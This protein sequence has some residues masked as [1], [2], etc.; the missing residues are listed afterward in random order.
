[1][2]TPSIGSRA[3]DA[4]LDPAP[5]PENTS[6]CCILV[7]TAFTVAVVAAAAIA[8]SVT[9]TCASPLVG[10]VV[11][12]ASLPL[13]AIFL[14]ATWSGS[15]RYVS[16][17]TP[18]GYAPLYSR[19]PSPLFYG[20]TRR[21]LFTES[22]AASR[23]GPPA[24]VAFA[25]RPVEFGYGARGPGLPFAFRPASFAAPRTPVG[26]GFGGVVHPM[27]P[28]AATPDAGH[29]GVGSARRR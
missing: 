25:D 17:S 26:G 1:M 21:P 3:P 2:A 16:Y 14:S 10:L 27:G 4:P 29:V 13:A 23:F 18:R 24:G 8:I 5:R 6:C 15:A 20:S 22:A 12:V 19:A 11:L 7:K 9:L 28:R